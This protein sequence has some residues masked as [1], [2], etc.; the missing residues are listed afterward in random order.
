MSTLKSAI[1]CLVL[2]DREVPFAGYLCRTRGTYIYV[3]CVTLNEGT[4]YWRVLPFRPETKLS[5]IV[6]NSTLLLLAFLSRISFSYVSI[7]IGGT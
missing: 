7:K 4:I 5:K 2:L 3:N 6:I 1:C